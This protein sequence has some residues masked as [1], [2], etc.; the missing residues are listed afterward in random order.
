MKPAL[1]LCLLLAGLHAV[2]H[3][4]HLPGHHNGHDHHEGT[5]H[6]EHHEEHHH[7][8]DCLK[9]APSNADFAFRLYKQ[10]TSEAPKKNIF[11]SPISISTAFAMLALGAKSDTL[12]QI[13]EGLAFNLTE[14]Q[15]KEIHDC[16]HNLIHILNHPESELQL[17][18]GNA[19]FLKEKLKTLE[20]FLADTKNLYE[21]E[22]FS[23][24]FKNTAEAQK[25]IN[26]YVEKKTHG[27]IVELVKDLDPETAMILVSYIFFKGKWEKPFLPEDTKERDFFVDE[28]TIVKV[29]MMHRMGRFDLH[30][31]TEL[32]CTVVRLYYNGSATAFF[33]L[34]N[35]GKMKQVEDALWKETVSRW[36]N[37]L[38]LSSA[39]LYIPKFSISATY[40]L[41][42]HLTKMGITDVF[43]KQAD[44][45]GITGDPELQVSRV[46]HKAV[47]NIDERGTEASAATA[48]EIMPMSLPLKIEFNSPFLMIIFDRTTNISLFVGKINNPAEP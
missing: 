36:S 43:T 7:V 31:D 26:D 27:K 2:A 3:C 14:L 29:P 24:N 21:G 12:T 23:I 6:E 10:I 13:L 25:H 48:I 20:K 9:L 4:D 28:E 18:M 38:H 19:L 16:F 46:V 35:K 41:K 33:I 40:D 15:E 30:F 17:D 22:A 34:P 1:Y 44:L 37:A 32:S 42:D 45:S 8:G 5:V 39:D 47:L 11:F